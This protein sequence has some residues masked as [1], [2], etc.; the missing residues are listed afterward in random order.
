[1]KKNQVSEK[2]KDMLCQMKRP[3]SSPPGEHVPRLN[4]RVMESFIY[5]RE[6]LHENMT[7]DELV[8]IDSID[9]GTFSSYQLD[10]LLPVCNK[11]VLKKGFP[12]KCLHNFD[13]ELKMVQMVLSLHL[14]TIFL[15]FTFQRLT[16]FNIFLAH[17]KYCM[18]S[19]RV[20]RLENAYSYL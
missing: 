4:P 6:K 5:N 20:E 13:N 3:L 7:N 17:G 8:I 14:L 19:T 18:L 12:V 10:Q 1:M 15:L 9:S 11:L 16:E 2:T